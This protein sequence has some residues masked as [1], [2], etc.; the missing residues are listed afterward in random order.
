MGNLNIIL[1]KSGFTFLIDRNIDIWINFKNYKMLEMA[2]RNSKKSKIRN[3]IL[4]EYAQSNYF[5]VKLLKPLFDILLTDNIAN[6]SLA[7]NILKLHMNSFS[8]ADRLKVEKSIKSF[9]KR[10]S[11]EDNLE[12]YRQN[13]LV[14]TKETFSANKGKMERLAFVKEQL[15]KPMK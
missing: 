1:I 13:L 14:P 6:A 10:K 12:F 11:T 9:Q 5:N 8:E 15:K 7:K 2:L 3:R 4:N